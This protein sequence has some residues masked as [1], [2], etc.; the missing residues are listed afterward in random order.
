MADIDGKSSTSPDATR[1]GASSPSPL[2]RI[3][4]IPPH[5]QLQPVGSRVYV[6]IAEVTSGFEKVIQHL[7]V[8]EQCNYFP[9]DI[10]TALL[11][12]VRHLQADANSHLLEIL[13]D[14]ELNNAGYYDRLCALREKE[15]QDPNDILIEAERIR[16]E[17]GG[18]GD[19]EIG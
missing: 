9:A 4:H 2:N 13:A 8:L 12:S 11:N 15:L 7:H 5:L 6:A 3:P 10:M 19:L 16:T 1:H 17:I 14:R 18:S